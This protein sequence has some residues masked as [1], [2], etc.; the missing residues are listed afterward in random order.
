MSSNYR[1][2]SISTLGIS[3]DKIKMKKGALGLMAIDVAP[4]I[5]VLSL[6]IKSCKKLMKKEQRLN[7]MISTRPAC[8][9][10]HKNRLSK[11]H[12]VLRVCKLL[13]CSRKPRSL[14]HHNCTLRPQSDLEDL[15]SIW[16]LAYWG[17][18]TILHLSMGLSSQCLEI[19]TVALQSSTS[20]RHL[21]WL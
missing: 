6:Q 13:P 5:L 11:S 3:V 18:A 9:R 2:E 20:I 14:C 12:I 21:W 4:F 15:R 16:S 10:Y 7:A 8:F 1:Q 19:C 17:S